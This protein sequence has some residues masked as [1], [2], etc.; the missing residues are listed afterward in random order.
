M[1]GIEK[2]VAKFAV[3]TAVLWE[4]ISPDGKGG[5]LFEEPIE[6][7]CRWDEKTEVKINNKGLNFASAASVLT[8][9]E[10]KRE[11]YLF[12]GTLED[13]TLINSDVSNPKKIKG[14]YAVI[15]MD[16]IPMVGKTDEFV[17]T[18][19]LFDYGK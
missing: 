6:I 19:Y 9:H 18:A 1:K 8:N 10:V 15:Q 17:R 16:K 12:L 4:Y 14:A 13:A 3:Q 5:A 7:L 2:V 11:D